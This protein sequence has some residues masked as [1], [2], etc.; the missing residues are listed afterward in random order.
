MEFI[1]QEEM[2]AHYRI[3]IQEILEEIEKCGDMI[4]R[5]EE[6]Q[7][8][9]WEGAAAESLRERLEECRIWQ[10][11]A[12]AAVEQAYGILLSMNMEC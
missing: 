9:G 5:L 4:I 1:T 10:R 8:K 2:Y 11:D 6:F 7:E 12:C 3:C